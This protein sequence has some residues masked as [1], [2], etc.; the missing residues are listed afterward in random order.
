MRLTRQT[1]KKRADGYRSGLESQIA[2]QIEAETGKPAVYEKLRIPYTMP[3]TEHHYTPDFQ[4]P[5]GIIVE[6]KGIFDAEDRKK[7]ELLKAQHPSLDIRFI[8]S[9]SK[10]PIN[11]KSPTSVGKWCTDRGY[12]Y[13]DK[14]IPTSWF[15][16]KCKHEA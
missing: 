3:Q 1:F 4:L 8:F 12:Q 2:R 14:V 6:G 15:K 7:H 16:E 5:N 13:A 9:S 11:P 10:K